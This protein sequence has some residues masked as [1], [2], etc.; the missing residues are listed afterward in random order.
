M[1]E[2]PMTKMFK[3]LA[4]ALTAA[5][6][7]AVLVPAPAG[8]A[9]NPYLIEFAFSEVP[10]AGTS[11]SA[12]GGATWTATF[13]DYSAG[14]ADASGDNG[15]GPNAG[16]FRCCS[17]PRQYSADGG[18]TW[19]ATR[20]QYNDGE[21]D[22][23]GDNGDGPTTGTFRAR[24][25]SHGRFSIDGGRT[26]GD[27]YYY[28]DYLAGE[29]DAAGDNGDGPD[30]GTFRHRHTSLEYSFDGG[31]TWTER[32]YQIWT[33]ESPVVLTVNA[34]DQQYLAGEDDAAGDNGDGPDAGTFRYRITSNVLVVYICQLRPGSNEWSTIATSR[35]NRRCSADTT[36]YTWNVDDG[37]EPTGDWCVLGR[38]FTDGPS[39]ICRGE[40]YTYREARRELGFG[41]GRP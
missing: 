35:P 29:A 34:L 13:A 8:A 31:S 23:A 17:W 11:F 37:I 36:T 19:T 16:T 6:L 32:T 12:D 10:G 28:Q 33:P 9:H 40:G 27:G 21:H 22:A 41:L 2:R 15:D 18:A 38:A 1:G 3:G 20:Q 7:A 25:S 4:A 30:A 39:I 24:I 14:E 26:G 5:T